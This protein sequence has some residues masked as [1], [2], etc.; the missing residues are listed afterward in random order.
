LKEA[1]EKKWPELIEALY[2]QKLHELRFD[3]FQE[4]VDT[5]QAWTHPDYFKIWYSKFRLL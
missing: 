5:D 3:V 4:A 1:I 2:K